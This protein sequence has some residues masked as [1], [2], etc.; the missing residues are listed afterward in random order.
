LSGQ[1][2]QFAVPFVALYVPGRHALHWPLKA[3]V[4]G[5]VYPVLHEHRMPDEQDCVVP[6]QG[7]LVKST[8]CFMASE[9]A[10]V[11][12]VLRNSSTTKT[13]AMSA[14]KKGFA[15]LLLPMKFKDEVLSVIV[16]EPVVVD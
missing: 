15:Q 7:V 13:P 11:V 16:V 5:P 14:F 10:V 6:S 3:P 4:S 1:A 2:V 8:P 9:M 12:S